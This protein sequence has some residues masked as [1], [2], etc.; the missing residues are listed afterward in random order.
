MGVRRD[1]YYSRELI[2]CV[3]SENDACELSQGIVDR[4]HFSASEICCKP[5]AL[6]S[7]HRKDRR[8]GQ[9]QGYGM[10]EE[11]LVEYDKVQLLCVH[12]EEISENY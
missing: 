12:K 1:A 4:D 8:I 7:V 9:K 5:V 10:A 6:Q 3:H 2:H 11:V